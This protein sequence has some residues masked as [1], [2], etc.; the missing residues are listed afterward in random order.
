LLERFRTSA[1]QRVL[2]CFPLSRMIDGHS[3]IYYRLASERGLTIRRVCSRTE[4]HRSDL[5]QNRAD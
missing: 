5:D 2:D 3:E 4:A 1:R